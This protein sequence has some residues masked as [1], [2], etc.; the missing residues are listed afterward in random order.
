MIGAF[1]LIG[2]LTFLAHHECDPATGACGYS[3]NWQLFSLGAS[4]M[5][6]GTAVGFTILPRRIDTRGVVDLW[7]ARHPDEPL[8]LE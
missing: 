2:S 8:T 6:A 1:V 3:T 5:I 7:N 4:A